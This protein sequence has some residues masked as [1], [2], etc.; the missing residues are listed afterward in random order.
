[1]DSR[2]LSIT[3]GTDWRKQTKEFLWTAIKGIKIHRELG[4]GR[5]RNLFIPSSP[6]P[7]PRQQLGTGF[8]LFYRSS[9]W[10]LGWVRQGQINTPSTK[11]PFPIFVPE[12]L[13]VPVLIPAPLSWKNLHSKR[14]CHHVNLDQ[15]H[16]ISIK[17]SFEF[18]KLGE[19]L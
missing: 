2:P 9:T 11:N 10:F 15:L 13:W 1:M 8:L 16:F 17:A 19:N 3:L 14:S 7:F 18:K 4:L 6:I 12:H 5:M